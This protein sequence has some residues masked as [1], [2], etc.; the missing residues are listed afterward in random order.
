M[1]TNK[2]STIF[3]DIGETLGSVRLSPSGQSIDRIDVFTEV[4][5]VL[6]DLSTRGARIG[7]ISNRGGIAEDEVKR[8][9]EDSGLLR[10][11]DPALIIF[12]RKDSTAIF[13]KAAA[14]AKRADTPQDCLFV[15][16]NPDER[17]FAELAG[18]RTAASPVDAVNIF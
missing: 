3:F 6:R 4:P 16:E 11:F 13:Q 1:E 12:G 15:G 9:L 5:E 10:F 7:I 18:L 17:S 8:A 14:L 2:L